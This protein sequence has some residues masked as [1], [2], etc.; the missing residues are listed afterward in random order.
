MCIVEYPQDLPGSTKLLNNY[1]SESGNTKNLRKISGK[2]QMGVAFTQT[3]GKYLTDKKKTN[4]KSEYHCFKCGKKYHWAAECPEIE[5]ER[6]A[7]Y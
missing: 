1:I 3:Q 2:E 5:E 6:K 4:N 7:T